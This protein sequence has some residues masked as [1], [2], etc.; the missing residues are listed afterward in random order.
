MIAGVKI[1]EIIVILYVIC[2]MIVFMF[3][4]SFML[5]EVE[6]DTQVNWLKFTISAMIFSALVS[7]MFP[8]V[9][10]VLIAVFLDE[11]SDENY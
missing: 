7:L 2:L 10:L 4:I 11:I 9:Y 3:S 6:K 8:F 5:D 1:S